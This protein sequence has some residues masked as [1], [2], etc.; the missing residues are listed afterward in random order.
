[1]MSNFDKLSF[2]KKKSPRRSR[3]QK[4]SKLRRIFIWNRNEKFE[5]SK[6]VVT[7]FD[8]V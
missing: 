2:G 7:L 3:K 6:F 8:S 4:S 5:L 1:M